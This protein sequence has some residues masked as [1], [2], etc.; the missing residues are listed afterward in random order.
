MNLKLRLLLQMVNNLSRPA[1][2]ARRDL[3]GIKSEAD[4]LKNAGTGNKLASDIEKIGAKAKAARRDILALGSAAKQTGRVAIVPGGKGVAARPRKERAGAEEKP[5]G[6]GGALI[7]GGARMVGGVA[8]YYA[9]R[10]VAGATVGKA[11]DFEKEM[12]DVKKKVDLPEGQNWSDL[13]KTITDSALKFG[14]SRAEVARLTSELGAAGIAYSELAKYIDMATRAG[15]AWDMTANEAGEKLM[16]V[17]AGLNYDDKQLADFVDK[18]NALSDAGASKERDVVEMA[19]RSAAAAK[20]SGVSEDVTMAF[21]TGMNSAGIQPEVASRGFNAMISKLRTAKSNGGDKM[22][23]GLKMLGLTPDGVEKGMKTDALKTL[24]DLLGRFAKA[25]DQAAAG[26]KIFGSEWWD[27]FARMAQA[28]PEIRKYLDI[29]GDGTKWRGSAQKN[30]NIEMA[31]AAAHLEKLKTL[32]EA[33]GERLGKWAL[34]PINS[35]IEQLLDNSR[36]ADDQLRR[37]EE[38]R[39]I[40]KKVAAGETL[41]PEQR[42]QLAGDTALQQQADVEKRAADNARE[43]ASLQ[44]RAELNDLR[45][46]IDDARRSLGVADPTGRD[47]KQKFRRDRLAALQAEYDQKANGGRMRPADRDD[48]N[49]PAR[50]AMHDASIQ[51]IEDRIKSLEK[52]ARLIPPGDPSSSEGAA[53]DFY[54]LT[55]R[56]AMHERDRMTYAGGPFSF[57]DGKSAKMPGSATGHAQ[58]MQF[59]FGKRMLAKLQPDMQADGAQIFERLRQ[60]MESQKGALEGT[61]TAARDGIE[62]PFKGMDLSAEGQAAMATLA[63]GIK[64]GESQAIAAANQAKANVMRALSGIGAGAGASVRGRLSGGLHDGGVAP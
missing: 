64:A 6:G 56:K 63:S 61:A 26:V 1:K 54:A 33:V 15:S 3:K 47:P 9:A 59:D 55:R 60:G 27:E 28:A 41:T 8:A 31:T 10:K 62:R 58:G 34:P 46:K 44:S 52:L 29:L 53:A 51:V 2:D 19:G 14:K 48:R 35:M 32:G 16:K 17:K 24:T 11:V 45:Q 39:E 30:V 5:A 7:A 37:M 40:R 25:K 12:A 22:T 42:Q 20:A 49:E 50:R 13:E 36:K 18:V 4:S 43:V 21:L 38:Q 23:E 57:A